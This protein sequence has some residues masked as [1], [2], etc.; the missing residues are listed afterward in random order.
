MAQDH[1]G[2]SPGTVPYDVA[3]F[4]EGFGAGLTAVTVSEKGREGF[5]AVFHYPDVELTVYPDTL[6]GVP[7]LDAFGVVTG[8]VSEIELTETLGGVNLAF[9]DFEAV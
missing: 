7:N 8:T 4:A 6:S 3:R 1:E 2:P 9:A 5:K